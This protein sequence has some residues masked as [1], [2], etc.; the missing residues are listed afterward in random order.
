MAHTVTLQ[1]PE[2]L[3]EPLV[4]VANQTGQTPEELITG[5]LSNAVQQFADHPI[6]EFIGAFSSNIPDWADRHDQYLGQAALNYN[7]SDV[8]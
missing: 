8:L 4:R 2:N 7:T 5:W 1:L 3:Y 6:E